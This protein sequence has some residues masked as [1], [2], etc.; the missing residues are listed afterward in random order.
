[1]LLFFSATTNSAAA[2]AAAAVAPLH[3]HRDSHS[4][5]MYK[6]L[7]CFLIDYWNHQECE[8]STD[9]A[10]V[11]QLFNLPERS[12]FQK[13][14]HLMG[15]GGGRICI[16]EV[17]LGT[18][19]VGNKKVGAGSVSRVGGGEQVGGWVGGGERGGSGPME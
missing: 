7:Q 4:K 6:A 15:P 8:T 11:Q 12:G 3:S 16:V 5:S 9:A 10:A 2:A 14:L 18:S 17:V 1:V 19:F 13:C